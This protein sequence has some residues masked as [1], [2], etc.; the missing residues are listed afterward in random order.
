MA[1]KQAFITIKDHKAGFNI[2]NP[3]CRLLNPTKSD[4][5][6]VSKNILENINI[7][8]KRKLNVNSWQSTSDVISWFN[9]LSDKAR[10]KFI[11]FDIEEFYPSISKK[12][13]EDTLN[14]AKN[15][16]DISELDILTIMHARKSILCD[17][18]GIYG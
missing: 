1:E 15:F 17:P 13:L 11:K 9:A 4:V 14:W 7:I 16:C 5:G 2:D 6:K 12:V 18:A 10:R 3:K 8:I